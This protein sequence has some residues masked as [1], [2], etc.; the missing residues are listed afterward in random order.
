[1]KLIFTKTDERCV[2]I[3]DSGNRFYGNIVLE[4]EWR[5]EVGEHMFTVDEVNQILTYMVTLPK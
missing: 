2:N 5:L 4:D 3:T 1:M